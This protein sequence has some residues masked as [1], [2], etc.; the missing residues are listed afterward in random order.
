MLYDEVLNLDQLKRNRKA[1]IK[2][3]DLKKINKL[4]PKSIK[5]DFWNSGQSSNM[6]SKIST[7]AP[8]GS[9]GEEEKKS[10]TKR[11]FSRFSQKDS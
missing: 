8:M 4:Y 6:N 10:V 5:D 3:L 11:R 2:K 7:V 9:I 1:L